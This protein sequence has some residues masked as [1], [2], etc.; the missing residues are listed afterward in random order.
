[1]QA[2]YEKF[3]PIE[4]LAEALNIPRRQNK[5][6]NA[7]KPSQAKHQLNFEGS[8]SFI[9]VCKAKNLSPL[10]L[11]FY[12]GSAKQM[13]FAFLAQQVPVD[14]YTVLI[15]EIKIFIVSVIIFM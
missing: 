1:M 8:A 2:Q 3:S 14:I 10:T 11:C 13:N 9:L 15:R 5:L 7:E 6:E 12:Q 4:H